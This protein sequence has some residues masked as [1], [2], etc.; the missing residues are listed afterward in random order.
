MRRGMLTVPPAPGTSPI[1]TS[2]SWKKA[3]SEAD[4]PAGEGRK[5]DA[6]THAGSVQLGA[7]PVGAVGEQASRVAG[8]SDGVG[9]GRV[10]EGAELVE[11]SSAAEGGSAPR[12]ITSVIEESQTDRPKPLHQGV[13]HLRG[14]GVPLLRS[15]QRE[16]EAG[17]GST[18]ENGG[19]QARLVCWRRGSRR[20]P[21]S[22]LRSAL[23]RGVHQRLRDQPLV[24]VEAGALPEQLDQRHGCEWRAPGG[25]E[26]RLELLLGAHH[27]VEVVAERSR[28]RAGAVGIEGHGGAGKGGEASLCRGD[29]F[30]IRRS[31]IGVEGDE[32]D[33]LPG[34]CREVF[35][36]V[37]RPQSLDRLRQR[38]DHGLR[39][40]VYVPSPNIS[41]RSF[42][43]SS[44]PSSL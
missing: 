12:R 14:E 31:S 4:H 20:Q 9:G 39:F 22:E 23:K 26:D 21:V 18:Q 19:L 29:G 1:A 27:D 24:D 16:L 36:G 3:S 35:G 7:Q 15:V 17:T 32:Q 8:G 11:V 33:R 30:G 34:Q 44:F 42:R 40:P 2:G 41:A 38:E 6:R 37:G 5:L 25:D 28:R 10:G 43:R 13:A